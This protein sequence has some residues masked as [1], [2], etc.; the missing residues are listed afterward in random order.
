M[1]LVRF[2]HSVPVENPALLKTSARNREKRTRKINC[3]GRTGAA[4]FPRVFRSDPC[5]FG[6]ERPR[7]DKRTRV[8]KSGSFQLSIETG[9][10]L[11]HSC[12]NREQTMNSFCALRMQRVPHELPDESKTNSTTTSDTR[13]NKPGTSQSTALPTFSACA[14]PSI[15]LRLRAV[16]RVAVPHAR[17][18]I[19]RSFARFDFQRHFPQRFLIHNPVQQAK[20]KSVVGEEAERPSTHQQAA[21]GQKR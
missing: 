9:Q 21:S 10:L 3:V 14:S 2:V 6:R 4:R 8:G 5:Q 16:E 7:C 11:R 19:E 1:A 18:E 12:C 20:R 13:S 15:A 17:V